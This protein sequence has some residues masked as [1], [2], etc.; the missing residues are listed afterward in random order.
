MSW[1]N[2]API[3]RKLLVAF[4]SIVAI[5]IVVGSVTVFE[6]RDVESEAERTV[7]VAETN[8]VLNDLSV[9]VADQVLSIRGLLLSGDRDNIARYQEAG[10]RFDRAML[11]AVERLTGTEGEGRLASLKGHVVAWRRDVAERQIALMRKPL[12]VDEARVIES[13]G[14][15]SDFLAAT[16]AEIQ[17]LLQQGAE[18][19]ASSQSAMASAFSVTFAVSLIGALVSTGLAAAGWLVLARSIVGPVAG[20]TTVM[21]RLTEGDLGADIPGA[22][23]GDELGRMARAVQVFK[24]GIAENRRLTE[25][26]RR[27]ADEKLARAEE[28][29]R[30]IARFEADSA[31]ML[32]KLAEQAGRMRS[33]A[34]QM[35]VVAE[36]TERQSTAVATAATEAGANVQNVAAATEELTA[37]IQD[38]SR[39]TQKASS[40]AA[41]AAQS[42]E[43]AS[44]VMSTLSAS[45]V[46]I[47]E[48]VKLITDIA[49]QT[50]L[51]A[52]NAT[53]EA[54]RAGE[55]GK[56]F[57]V[58]ASEVKA[59]ATQTAKATEDIR[60]Q[61]GA[62]Q[63][64]T[65]HAVREI[66]EVGR[67][68]QGVEE[69]STAIAAAMEQQTA[70][71]Q[72][73][74]RNVS[75]A[76]HGTDV[77]VTN[78][79]GVSDA[80][81]ESGRQAGEVLT[82]ARDIAEESDRMRN[83]VQSFLERIQSA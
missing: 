52:L 2:N 8:R 10:G 17:A 71:T 44:A 67:I 6:I 21:G 4:A 53:I 56:G 54:A 82:V 7:A 16:D 41:Q 61:I 37:S 66:A 11:Q 57:A 76:A 35:S 25:E 83:S 31:D 68:I 77:V 30:L 22:G 27:A 3:S 39:Q 46:T 33:T 69:V 55:A 62:I 32:A 50:N 51:L 48:V 49:E 19:L 42:T 72:D 65:D 13:N 75:H 73:I 24:D 23:R 80:A 47:G 26:Q 1:L 78:I 34:Q 14:A 59:L 18:S 70:A 28:V 20:L 9:A 81:G 40:D 58:V 60:A 43:R 63:G 15:G 36:E 12:T 29:A 74:S 64:E 38:I 5:I 79:Q 45:A